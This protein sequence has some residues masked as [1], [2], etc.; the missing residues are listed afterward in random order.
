V[1]QDDYR[2]KWSLFHYDRTQTAQA[3]KAWLLCSKRWPGESN[4][5]ESFLSQKLSE[6]IR[7]PS[8]S[9][10]YTFCLSQCGGWG[11]VH[12]LGNLSGRIQCH[13]FLET[14]QS[15][16]SLPWAN[17]WWYCG[18]G[19]LLATLQSNWSGTCVL[20]QWVIPFT[21]DFIIPP[22]WAVNKCPNLK[23]RYQVGLL[24]TARELWSS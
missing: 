2:P 17:I 24:M 19:T 9:V 3:Y 4:L 6:N 8:S 1:L 15:A 22:T 14:N 20:V 18:E 11:M 23:E 7:F 5:L 12:Y 13:M 21:P 16:L 10:N